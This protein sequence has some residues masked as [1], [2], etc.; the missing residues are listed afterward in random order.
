MLHAH[1]Q[2]YTH[3]PVFEQE[4]VTVLCNQWVHPGREVTENRPYIAIKNKEEKTFILIDMA[5]P[6]DRKVVQ[7]KAEMKIK[8]KRMY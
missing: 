1:T 4:D 7:K 2:T 5:V 3:K 8:Y 6:A